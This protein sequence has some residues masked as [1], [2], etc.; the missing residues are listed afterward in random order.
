MTA[1][2]RRYRG[3]VTAECATCDTAVVRTDATPPHD[4][5]VVKTIRELI[6]R[7]ASGRMRY[8]RG[9]VPLEDMLALA[10]SEMRYTVVSYLECVDC[11]R[12]RFWGL[13]VRGAPI[14]RVAAAGEPSART[15]E[16]VPPRHLWA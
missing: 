7:V 2:S 12:T 3:R 10:A 11:G 8:L 14:Y 9:D 6:D 13:C 5:D 15:W 16:P 1:R 4:V